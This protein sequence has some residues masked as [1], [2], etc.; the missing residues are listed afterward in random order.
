[1][2]GNGVVLK[3]ASNVQGCATAIERCFIDA[4]YY[5]NIFCNLRIPGSQVASVIE[6]NNIVAVTLTGS[7]PA[8]QAVAKKAGECLKKT[9]LEFCL[10]YTSP[11]PRD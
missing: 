2:V 7:T 9:V 11:S 8:G 5:E 10:L 6:N 3:H 4:G 1:M